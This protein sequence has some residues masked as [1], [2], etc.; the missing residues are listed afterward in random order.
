MTLWKTDS[1]YWHISK[2]DR[3][4]GKG[5]KKKEEKK[6]LCQD[7]HGSTVYTMLLHFLPPKEIQILLKQGNFNVITLRENIVDESV[8]GIQL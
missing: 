5:K 3:D 6:L 4:L 1:R 2:T 7:W 8:E